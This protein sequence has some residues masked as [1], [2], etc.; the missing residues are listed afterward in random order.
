MRGIVPSGVLTTPI[1]AERE[2]TRA[3]CGIPG[4]RIWVVGLLLLD[5]AVALWRPGG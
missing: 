5:L 2:E 3:V 4:R 1:S